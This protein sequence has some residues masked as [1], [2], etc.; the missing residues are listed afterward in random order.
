LIPSDVRV[1]L[2]DENQFLDAL[3][4]FGI[5]DVCIDRL[6]KSECQVVS[7]ALVAGKFRYEVTDKQ[8][9]SYSLKVALKKGLLD[10][11]AGG[12][13]QGRF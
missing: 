4:S 7:K 13:T 11:K 3:A 2:L 1:E 12:D 10:A 6:L 8:Q 9:Q 5:R